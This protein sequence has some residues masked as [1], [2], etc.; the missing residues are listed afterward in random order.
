MQMFFMI[1]YGLLL[2]AGIFFGFDRTLI[3]IVPG[4]LLVLYAHF[5]VQ[6]TFKKWSEVSSSSTGAEIARQILDDNGIHNVPVECIPGQLTDHYDPRTRVVRLSES[7][8][9]SN[10]IAAIA[11]AAHE[12]GHAVQHAQ[13]YAPLM[14]RNAVAPVVGIMSNAWSFLVIAGIFFSI[15]YLLNIGVIFFAAFFLFSAITL[16]VE[17]D[18]SKRALT[19]LEMDGH[20]DPTYELPGAKKV[21]DAAAMTYVA[22]AL[23]ALLQL[24]RLLL[25]LNNRD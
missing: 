16:P 21:L 11:V 6:S 25:I 4:F 7:T 15:P 12:V 20:L 2:F 23:M 9:Y 5:K 14:L 18:A 3:L 1:V 8:Y 24:I 13:S 19:T 10:S 22:G 17:F